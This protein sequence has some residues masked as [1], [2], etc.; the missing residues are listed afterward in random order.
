[1]ATLELATRTD[2]VPHY[3]QRTALDGIDYLFTFRFGE[4]RAAWVFDMATLDGVAIVAGQ[5]VLCAGQDLL[6]RSAVPEKPPGILW[7]MN[8]QSPPEGGT[9]ALPGLYDLGGPDGRA[10]IFY[11]EAL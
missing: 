9:F 4:R 1:M 3:Q 11:T 5:L 10:R 8:L 7:A 6:R 2:G